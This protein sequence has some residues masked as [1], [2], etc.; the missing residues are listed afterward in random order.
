MRFW[1]FL[2]V[3]LVAW[4]AMAPSQVIARPEVHGCC[5][6]ST[7]TAGHPQKKKSKADCCDQGI[8]NPFRP[9]TCCAFLIQKNA[10]LPAVAAFPVAAPS[11]YPRDMKLL[12]SFVGSCFHPP[13]CLPA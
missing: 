6:K 4:S 5:K 1:A 3:V 8:C 11:F 9:C 7:N 10:S 13:E 12:R 2:L